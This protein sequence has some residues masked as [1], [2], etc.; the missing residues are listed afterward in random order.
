VRR[1]AILVAVFAALIL[2]LGLNAPAWLAITGSVMALCCTGCGG[3]FL[4]AWRRK[5]AQWGQIPANEPCKE[6]DGAGVVDKNRQPLKG[7]RE[8]PRILSHA[9]WAGGNNRTC[10][11]CQGRGY[12][13]PRKVRKE[14]NKTPGPVTK[15]AQPYSPDDVEL[16]FPEGPQ[17]PQVIQPTEIFPPG[18]WKDDKKK[19]GQR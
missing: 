6:C 10:R 14:A 2:V 15:L 16:V 12:Y 5:I 9:L 3:L 8:D 13:T 18:F 19:R 4:W 1:A 17:G 11:Q 7:W